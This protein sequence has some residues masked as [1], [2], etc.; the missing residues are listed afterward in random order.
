V[1]FCFD[2]R[3]RGAAMAG[4]EVDPDDGAGTCGAF[5][6]A[7]TVLHD[8]G[9]TRGDVCC[10]NIAEF[11]IADNVAAGNDGRFAGLFLYRRD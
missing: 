1:S 2:F 11:A 3:A 10:A 4:N 8:R 5:A 7:E 9:R 6:S